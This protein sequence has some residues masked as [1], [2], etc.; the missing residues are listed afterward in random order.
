[1]VERVSVIIIQ[2]NVSD[3]VKNIPSSTKQGKLW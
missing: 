2:I 3:Y 1:M